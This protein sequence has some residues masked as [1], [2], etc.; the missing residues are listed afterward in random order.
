MDDSVEWRVMFLTGAILPVVMIILVKTVMPESPRWLVDNG[1]EDEAI[2]ILQQIYPSGK[3]LSL[4]I[5]LLS[6]VL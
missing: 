6:S 4:P 3:G 1:R 5:Y 2:V